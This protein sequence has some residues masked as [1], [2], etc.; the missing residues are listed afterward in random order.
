MP[1]MKGRFIPKHPE[2]YVGNVNKIFFRSS[3]EMTLLRWL[4]QS[5]AVLRWASEELAIPYVNP[6]KV[7]PNGRPK[8]SHYYPDFIILYKDNLGRIKKEIVEVKPYKETVLLP[9]APERDKLAY[10]VNR[11]KWQAADRFA[12]SQGASFRVITE[13][14]MFPK[15]ASRRLK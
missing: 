13:R 15:G 1:I 3:W 10:A 5:N 11:A 6:I 8:V 4:D 14:S 12:E 7:D 2:K 9:G